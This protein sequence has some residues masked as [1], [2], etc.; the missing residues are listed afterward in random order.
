LNVRAGGPAG[1]ELDAALT[2]QERAG[3]NDT[4]HR[5]LEARTCDALADAAA[6]V[7]ALAVDPRAATAPSSAQDAVPEPHP[8]DAP[9]PA[10]QGEP[11]P[12]RDTPTATPAPKPRRPAPPLEVWTGAAAGVGAFALPSVTATVELRAELARGRLRAGVT[13]SLWTP[14]EGSTTD[15]RYGGR[16]L[17]WNA[18]PHACFAPGRGRVDVPLCLAP[19]F[20]LVHGQGRGELVARQATA[21]WVALGAGGAVRIR[22]HSRLALRV[23]LG[24]AAV[25]LRPSFVV[26]GEGRACCA[27]PWELHA[28]LGLDARAR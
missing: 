15:P 8:R 14:A 12:P 3:A 27:S 9:R 4:T 7:V 10:P 28:T 1:Y 24:A 5:H 26:D 2:L 13:T 18:T 20:G 16:F 11:V 23:G 21:P 19:A 25:L 17:L 6:L 22:V